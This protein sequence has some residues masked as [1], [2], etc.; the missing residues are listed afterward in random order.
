MPATATRGERLPV[1]RATPAIQIAS[2]TAMSG[3]IQD[4]LPD[5]LSVYTMYAPRLRERKLKKYSTADQDMLH[6]QTN[7]GEKIKSGKSRTFI[8]REE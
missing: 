4:I 5:F 7:A 1:A 3:S 8:E 2:S 6:P